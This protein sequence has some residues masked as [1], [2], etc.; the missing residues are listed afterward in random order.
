MASNKGPNLQRYMDKVLS[1]SLNG[2]RTV[3]GILRGYDAFLNIVLD[4]AKEVLP[5]G[6][7]EE[8]GQVV[9][10]G[11]SVVQFECKGLVDR[12]QKAES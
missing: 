2:N 9:V 8:I 7:E 3:N 5:G 12:Q 11:N 6:V 1:V 4:S 10:R